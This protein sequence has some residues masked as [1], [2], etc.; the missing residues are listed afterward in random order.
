MAHL[1]RSPQQGHRLWNQSVRVLPPE[2]WSTSALP[3]DSSDVSWLRS[4]HSH[5]LNARACLDVDIDNSVHSASD[6]PT[7]GTRDTVAA[8]CRRYGILL[9]LFLLC[10]GVRRLTTGNLPERSHLRLEYRLEG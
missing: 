9:F 10:N 3:E 6:K 2:S 7:H 8:A 5:L 1:S 4:C